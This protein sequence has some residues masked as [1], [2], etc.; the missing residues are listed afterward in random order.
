MYK[1]SFTH[2][3]AKIIIDILFYVSILCSILVPFCSNRIFEWIN[4]MNTTYIYSFASILFVS[5]ILC[6]YIL[7]NLKQMYSSLLVGNPF[8]DKN[9]SHLRK[10]AV[11]CFLISV[12]YA[13]KCLFMFTLAT[14]IISGIFIIGCLFC[15]TLKDLFKQAINYK[16]ENDLTI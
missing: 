8:V 3:A 7:F 14:V 6:S 13:L 11:A 15:L 2:Y 12:I 1:K 16:T 5:G 4:Y 9:V 10:M